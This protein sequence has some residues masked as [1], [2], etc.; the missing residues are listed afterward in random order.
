[1]TIKTDSSGTL[2]WQRVDSYKATGGPALG[3]S[4][5]TASSAAG[6]WPILTT[7]GKLVIVTDQVS[8]IG[9]LELSSSTS[10]DTS[11][12]APGASVVSMALVAVVSAAAIFRAAA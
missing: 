4:G 10:S 9:I 8:G 1:M 7:G 2:E 11:S 5:W 6:E 12:A 3:A